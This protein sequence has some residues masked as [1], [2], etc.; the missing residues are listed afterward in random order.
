MT[1]LRFLLFILIFAAVSIAWMVL[2][3]TLTFRTSKLQRSLSQEVD[4]LWGPSN[5]MQSAPHT[6]TGEDPLKSDVSVNFRHH[7]RYKGLLWFSTYTVDFA[8]AYTHRSEKGGTFVFPLPER[9]PFFE[10]LAVT[11]DGKPRQIS[12]NEASGNMLEVELPADGREH[13]VSVTYRTR[14][15]DR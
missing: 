13:I 2:G 15:R 8:G 3:G 7:N 1:V 4:N 5:L 11:L 12:Y 10:N 6:T 14:G 9:A